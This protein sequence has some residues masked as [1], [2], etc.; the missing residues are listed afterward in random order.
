[1]QQ[2]QV[3]VSRSTQDKRTTLN[4]FSSLCRVHVYR[5]VGINIFIN[6][7]H[8]SLV[9]LI[10]C[11]YFLLISLSKHIVTRIHAL[12]YVLKFGGRMCLQFTL[13]Y[14]LYYLLHLTT[15]GKKM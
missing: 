11:S 13:K 14:Y 10:S 7:F 6:V 12:D 9:T 4:Y 5:S 1:M 8:Y 3:Q 15:V 2:N